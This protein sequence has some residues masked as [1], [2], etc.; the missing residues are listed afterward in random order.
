METIRYTKKDIETVVTCLLAGQVIAFPTDTVYGLAIVYDQPKALQCLKKAKKRPDH[1]PIPMMVA[2][3]AQIENIAHVSKQAKQLIEAFMPGAFTIILQKK[4]VIPD[5]ITNGFDTIA[6][7]I[8]DDEFIRTI[9][10]QCNKPLLVTSANLSG[11]ETG[12]TS[13][14]VLQQLDHRIDGIVLG[15]ANGN[16]ASTIVDATKEIQVVREGNIS[17]TMIERILEK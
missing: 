2:N 17:K 10:Q 14:A 9:I 3:V 15:E 13:K 8:P 5:D 11:Q 16:V 12:I 4:E 6:I 7:R 1:K